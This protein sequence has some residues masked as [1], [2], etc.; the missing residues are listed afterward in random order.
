MFTLIKVFKEFAMSICLSLF[1]LIKPEYLTLVSFA[2][3]FKS[4]TA[5]RKFCTI[6][7]SFLAVEAV[8]RNLRRFPS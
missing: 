8:P 1:G 6:L 4:T 5:T 3:A 2:I 7:S